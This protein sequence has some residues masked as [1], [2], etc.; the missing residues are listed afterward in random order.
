MQ[1]DFEL[2]W[3]W[4]IEPPRTYRELSVP[5][6]RQNILLG[7]DGC[8]NPA[9]PLLTQKQDLLDFTRAIKHSRSKNDKSG[10]S[11][12]RA[13]Q[14]AFHDWSEDMSWS[15]RLLTSIGL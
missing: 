3:S 4:P 13:L 5:Q 15:R 11:F 6:R 7:R 10:G 12:R 2:V 14:Y 1:V 8:R 9:L